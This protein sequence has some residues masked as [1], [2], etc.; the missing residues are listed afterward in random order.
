MGALLQDQPDAGIL[1]LVQ[2]PSYFIAVDKEMSWKNVGISH[3]DEHVV[4]IVQSRSAHRIIIW[5]QHWGRLI[6][7]LEGGQGGGPI[8]LDLA[9]ICLILRCAWLHLAQTSVTVL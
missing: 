3:D 5:E 9:P 4:A 2:E 1:H 8:Y 6:T 7:V